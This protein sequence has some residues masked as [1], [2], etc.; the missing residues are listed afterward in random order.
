LV[1]PPDRN[2]LF[3]LRKTCDVEVAPSDAQIIARMIAWMIT[4]IG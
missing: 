1:A 2:L 4:P 3:A